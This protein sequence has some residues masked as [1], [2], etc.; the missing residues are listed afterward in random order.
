MYIQVRYWLITTIINIIIVLKIESTLL[1]DTYVSDYY[2][3]AQLVLFSHLLLTMLLFCLYHN[4][5]YIV[6]FKT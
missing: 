4:F 3:L 2:Y 6:I 5:R 1:N